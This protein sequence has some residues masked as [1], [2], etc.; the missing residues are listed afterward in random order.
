V[1]TL[2]IGLSGV[3]SQGFISRLIK[4]GAW[5]GRYPKWAREFS[6]AWLVIDDKG[7]IVEAVKRGVRPANISKYD[8]ADYKL[9]ALEMDERDAEQVIAFANDVVAHRWKY[10][11]LTFAAC[12]FSC[13]SG[14]IRWLPTFSFAV[15]QTAICSGFVCDAL[16]RAGYIWAKPTAV[17]MPADLA[18]HFG[19]E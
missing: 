1:T 8:P 17:M 18:V 13:L 5:V 2:Q 9:I 19:V 16:T 10:G 6:H 14:Q 12:G 7:S 4:F 15:A 3:K 11:F